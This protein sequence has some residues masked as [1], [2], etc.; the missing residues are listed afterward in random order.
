[1]KNYLEWPLLITQDITNSNKMPRDV[2]FTTKPGPG[3]PQHK[4]LVCRRACADYKKTATRLQHV[5]LLFLL[6]LQNFKMRKCKQCA[7]DLCKIY[8]GWSK[9]DCEGKEVCYNNCWLKAY[10]IHVQKPV[11]RRQSQELIRTQQL[12]TLVLQVI[13]KWSWPDRSEFV[14]Q[15]F[16]LKN[17]LC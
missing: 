6:A 9:K 10:K 14:V 4:R 3:S 16:H 7:T 12:M 5:P 1:M 2:L 8:G 15:N 13:P 17:S 11:F